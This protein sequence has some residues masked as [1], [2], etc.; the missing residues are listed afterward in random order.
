MLFDPKHEEHLGKLEARLRGAQAIT[1]D[2]RSDAIAQ[3]CTRFAAQGSTVRAKVNRLI[4]CGG[5]VDA[6]LAVVELQLPRWK[7]RRAI[8]EDGEWHCCLSKQPGLPLGLDEVSE[9]SHEDLALAILIALLRVR[10]AADASA[11]SSTAVSDVRPMPGY[12]VCCDNFA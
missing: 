3:A 6:T 9:A 2:L 10:R 4:E 12:A 5:W 11:A 1:P 8:W 7:L